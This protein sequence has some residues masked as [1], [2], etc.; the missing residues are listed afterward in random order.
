[1]SKL[2]VD[3]IR[4]ADRSVSSTANIT[5]ADDGKVNFAENLVI[6]NGKGIDFSAVS[7]SAS[8]SSSAL[9][10]DYEEGAWTPQ[11]TEGTYNYTMNSDNAGRYIKVG[12][13]VHI[14]AM[15]RPNDN[16]HSN[17]NY[18]NQAKITGLPF[19]SATGSGNRGGFSIGYFDLDDATVIG[20]YAYMNDNVTQIELYRGSSSENA[21][22][23][24]TISNFGGNGAST[25]HYIYLSGTYITS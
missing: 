1:M 4:S 18:G 11:L 5:L 17:G 20:I 2:K 9:L 24:L 8:G 16:V 25:A 23:N 6:A 15:V 10:D 7:G 14:S 19:T 22:Q 13:M 12:N 3:E 21:T